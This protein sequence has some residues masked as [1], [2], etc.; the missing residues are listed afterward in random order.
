MW[1]IIEDTKDCL[2]LSN[3]FILKKAWCKVCGEGGF[4]FYLVLR[5]IQKIHQHLQGIFGTKSVCVLLRH[6]KEGNSGRD[7]WVKQLWEKRPDWGNEWC[8]SLLWWA[9]PEPCLQEAL[10]PKP[11]CGS[12]FSVTHTMSWLDSPVQLFLL[13]FCDPGGESKHHIWVSL[14]N[15][16]ELNKT[17]HI[18]ARAAHSKSP[19]GLATTEHIVHRTT[20]GPLLVKTGLQEQRPWH[21]DRWCPFSEWFTLALPIGVR[22]GT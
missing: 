3:L 18:Q 17:T 22:D 16:V 20:T 1:L 12:R 15:Q 6:W 10:L 9:E 11:R 4:Y 8:L 14:P 21:D 13:L 2:L 5:C 19:I 7:C